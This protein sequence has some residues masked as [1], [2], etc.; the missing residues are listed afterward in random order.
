M[1]ND[2]TL[3]RYYL[4]VISTAVSSAVGLND[5]SLV[6]DTSGNGLSTVMPV[7]EWI[8][9]HRNCLNLF[10]AWPEDKQYQ[11]GLAEVRAT[12]FIADPNSDFPS[13]GQIIGRAFWPL[14]TIPEVY[15]SKIETPFDADSP[16]PAHLWS[17]A[18]PIETLAQSDQTEIL[19]LVERLRQALMGRNFDGAFR[20]VEYRYADDARVNGATLERL[21]DIVIRQYTDMMNE[22]SPHS[23]PIDPPLANFDI[24]ANKRLVRVSH[25]SNKEAVRIETEEGVSSIDV[26][27]AKVLGKWTIVRG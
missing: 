4:E 24:I 11:L 3:R 1:P 27:A 13:P 15:P 9:P 10:V 22:P 5:V 21:R 26:Y 18:Q 16:P 14:P 2:P 17:E 25:A 19:D 7:N 6:I 12:I 23:T 8:I 20:L